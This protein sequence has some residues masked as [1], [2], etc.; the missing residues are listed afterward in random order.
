MGSVVISIDAEL[1]WGFSDFDDP[2]TDWAASGREGW[3]YLL[4]RFEEYRM[5]ATWAV[6]GHLF[7]QGRTEAAGSDLTPPDWLDRERSVWD[8]RPELQFGNGLVTALLETDVEH[9]IGS[10]TFSHI[11]FDKEWV[12]RDTVRADLEAAI[13][14]GAE[15]GV[16]YESFVFP[17]NVVG[18]RDVLADCGFNAYRGAMPEG[19]DW[20][21]TKLAAL[22][23]PKATRLVEPYVDEYGL[24]NVPPSLYLFEMEGLARTAIESIWAGPIV[25]IASN[26]I[27]RAIREDGLFHVWL[28]PNN[29]RTDRDFRRMGAVLELID[30]RRGDGLAVETMADVA[31]RVQSAD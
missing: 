26:G 8:L 21:L 5:P 22:G 12:T 1:G 23:T 13:E 30:D 20:A 4:D 6:V 27:D 9:D 28:H 31:R 24:V 25:E 18:Y 29:L 14:A 2:P 7:F 10:H 3:Q 11:V 16:E 17:R 19:V 15:S